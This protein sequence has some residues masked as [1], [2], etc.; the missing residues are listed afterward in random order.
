MCRTIAA[1]SAAGVILVGVTSLLAAGPDLKRDSDKAHDRIETLAM[2]KMI[3]ALDLDQPTADKILEIRRK[4]LS[5]R[6]SLK[7]DLSEDFRALR[8]QLSDPSK[9][10]DDQELAQL[11]QDIRAKRKELQG[12]REQLYDEVSKVLTV[13]QRAQLVLF[14]RDF[15]RELRSLLPPPPSRAGPEKGMRPPRGDPGGPDRGMGLHRGAPM[16]GAKGNGPSRLSPGPPE[17]G[18]RPPLGPPGPLHQLDDGED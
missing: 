3:E 15:R 16:P 7:K 10:A 2:W 5:Q 14:F 4:F 12:I 17:I 11:L 1:L 18:M 9:P 8:K 13:R 6:K